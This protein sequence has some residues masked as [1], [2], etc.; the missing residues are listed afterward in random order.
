MVITTRSNDW[1]GTQ[2]SN[3]WIYPRGMSRVGDKTPGAMSWKSKY[4]SITVSG[5]D[6]ATLDGLNEKGLSANA[7]YLSESDYGK[8]TP[9]DARKP[10]SHITTPAAIFDIVITV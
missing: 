1:L 6:I 8:P 7:L 3:L 4:G 5:W 10:I 9:G 2:K